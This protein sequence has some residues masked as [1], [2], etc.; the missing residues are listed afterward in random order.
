MLV[1]VVTFA[2]KEGM[3][4]QLKEIGQNLLVPINKKAGSLHAY[5]LEPNIEDGNPLFGVVSVWPDKETVD[6]MKNSEVYQALLQTISPLIESVTDRLYS[7][8]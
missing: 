8:S 3:E 6:A 7:T 2:S 5:F 1:R 4:N